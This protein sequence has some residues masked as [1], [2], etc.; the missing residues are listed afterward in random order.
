VPTKN[1]TVRFIDSIDPPPSGRV[2]YFDAGTKGFGLRV[3]A[4]GRMTWVVLYRY[5]GT[6]RRMTLGTY[7]T[8][9]LADAREAA[10]DALRAAAKGKD[11]AGEKKAA[12]EADTFAELAEDYIELHAKPNKRSWK[13]DR[14]A[15]DRDLLPTF[16]LRKAADVK[17][18]DVKKLLAEIKARGAPVL[19]N[20]TLEI[21]RKI[22][23]WAIDE[24]RVEI[25]PC[26]GIEPFTEQSRDRVLSEDEIR[27]VWKALDSQQQ[28]AAARFRLL[29]L[30]AQRYGEVRQMRWDDIAD[31]WWTI[32]AEFSK[33]RL[34]HRVP[35]SALALAIVD[36]LRELTGGAKWVF[37][38][39]VNDAA[40]H[41][42]D[43]RLITLR[44]ESGVNFRAHDLRRTAASYM[45]SMGI[46]R[47]T[48]GR[49]LNHVETSVTATYDRHSY[50]KEKRRALDAW[51]RRLKEI[52]AGKK[53]ADG[54]VL[55]FRPTTS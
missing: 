53:P 20:R 36:G 30:T 14:R 47:F 5:L 9:T 31:G 7:P 24:E 21:M 54:K 25:N 6:K 23:N 27:A 15:L 48:I 44:K 33:N 41:S 50:D 28:L 39:P 34:S 4:A 13:E 40:V 2:E 17:R 18:R 32:P 26:L 22:Y 51:A 35:L 43:K 52:L 1:L 11:P 37:P 55:T 10:E 42:D 12:R 49:V 16:R 19:A 45:G 46:G 8:V 29:L 38:S 3:T